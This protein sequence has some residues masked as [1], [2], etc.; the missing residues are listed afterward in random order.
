MPV[1]KISN[2]TS[3]KTYEDAYN[4]F[5]FYNHIM[6]KIADWGGLQNFRIGFAISM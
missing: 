6:L 4:P 1:E 2:Q 5:H 3:N